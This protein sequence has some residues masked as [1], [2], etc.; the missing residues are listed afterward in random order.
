MPNNKTH[1]RKVGDRVGHLKPNGYSTVC[2]DGVAIPLHRII[3]K[4]FNGD[5]VGDIDHI[6]GNPSNNRIENLRISTSSQNQRNVGIRKD[7]TSGVKNVSYDKSKNS[8]KVRLFVDGKNKII[9]D[10]KDLEL[11]ELVAFEARTKFHGEFA[12]HGYHKEVA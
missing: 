3:Y 9:G 7:N 11:A 4:M 1:I 6:D 8:W 12:N 10:F 5:F 2:L